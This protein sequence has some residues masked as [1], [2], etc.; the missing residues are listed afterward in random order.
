MKNSENSQGNNEMRKSHIKKLIM[1]KN[2]DFVGEEADIPP[3]VT[4]D[5]LQ[6]MET[7]ST[8]PEEK[9]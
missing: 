9:N 1:Q 2:C 6:K 8:L 4:E 5:I 7:D 3:P